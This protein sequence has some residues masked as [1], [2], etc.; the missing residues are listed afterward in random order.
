MDCWIAARANKASCATNGQKSL[1]VQ[2]TLLAGC[3]S[4]DIRVAWEYQRN[5]PTVYTCNGSVSVS[6]AKLV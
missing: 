1:L 2:P 4:K 3:S 6:G 5:R